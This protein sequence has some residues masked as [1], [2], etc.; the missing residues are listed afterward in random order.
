[1]DFIGLIK[2]TQQVLQTGLALEIEQR[3]ISNN[4]KKAFLVIV[5]VIDHTFGEK[6]KKLLVIIVVAGEKVKDFQFLN[7]VEFISILIEGLDRF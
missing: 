7:W 5:F 2:V 6:W 1:M 4:R 3:K